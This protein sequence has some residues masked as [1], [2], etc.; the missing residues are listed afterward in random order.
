MLAGATYRYE[1]RATD[2]DNGTGVLR[3]PTKSSMARYCAAKREVKLVT[4]K[5]SYAICCF[6][7]ENI[8]LSEVVI[9]K[10]VNTNKKSM[11][12]EQLLYAH[13]ACLRKHI[14]K[15]VPLMIFADL[16]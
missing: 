8:P 15:Q 1:V 5:K 11:P 3:G 4:K 12:N 2:A 7:I 10:L 6:C 14:S 13:V 16:D 9:V